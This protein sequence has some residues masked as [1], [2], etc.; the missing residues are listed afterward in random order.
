M[1]SAI[2]TPLYPLYQDKLGFSAVVLSW[3]FSLYVCG[4]LAVLLLVGNLSDNVGRRPVLLL[5]LASALLGSLAFLALPGISGLLVGRTLHGVAVGVFGAAGAATL[6]DLEPHG[7]RSRA[8]LFATLPNMLGLVVGSLLSGEL[9]QYAPFPLRLPWLAEIAFLLSATILIWNLND[10]WRRPSTGWWRPQPLHVPKSIRRLF[11]A[12]AAAGFSLSAI[13][14][15]FLAVL[16]N[17]IGTVLHLSGPARSGEVVALLFGASAVAELFLR[18]LPTR[19][20]VSTGL[21][22]MIAGLAAI[23]AAELLTSM[24]LFLL[25]TLAAGLGQGL[26]LT[27]A[28][29]AV[30]LAS[31]SGQRSEIISS[32]Y[33]FNYLGLAVPVLG[34][35]AASSIMGV[36][37][38]TIGFAAVIAG[39]ALL[40]LVA[41]LRVDPTRHPDMPAHGAL[42]GSPRLG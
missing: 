23:V 16:P 25:G 40:G 10:D 9:A 21:I 6:A 18:H 14:G 34:V 37:P 26:T 15:L 29:A 31:P 2:P 27:G 17:L 11:V 38:A 7:D 12:A 22:G 28:L 4:T 30:N 13:M 36:L 41:I 3:I 1:A 39:V 20:A 42:A 35:G 5:A 33:V 8:A 32:L 19:T 24:S